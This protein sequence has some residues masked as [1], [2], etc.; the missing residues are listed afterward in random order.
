MKKAIA[1]TALLVGVISPANADVYVKVDA[2]GNAI[3]EAIVCEASVCGNS[4]SGYSRATLKSGEQYVLQ[5]RGDLGIGNNNQNTTLKVDIE[6]QVW[7][8][9][10]PTT[11][12]KFSPNP[13]A[14]LGE[15]FP[16]KPMYVDTRTA[17]IDTATV[18]LDTTTA[19]IDTA[20]ATI[21]NVTIESLYTKIMALFTQLLALIAKLKG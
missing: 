10:T 7:T 20:T 15:V 11:V 16:A 4:N 14:D 19:T 21:S 2:N 1:I 12:S 13:Q 17:T 8:A 9:T 6:T 3:G 5:G 18:L